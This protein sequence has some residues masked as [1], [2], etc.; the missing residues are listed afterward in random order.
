MYVCIVAHIDGSATRNPSRK[1]PAEK[2]AERGR[3]NVG[4]QRIYVEHI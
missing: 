1:E 3:C 2:R 4:P